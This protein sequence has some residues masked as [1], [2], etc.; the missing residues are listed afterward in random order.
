MRAGGTLKLFV[1]ACLLGV[2]VWLVETRVDDQERARLGKD[3]VFDVNSEDVTHFSISR[4]DFR[5]GFARKDGAW[6]LDWPVR[7]RADAGNVERVLSALE[8]LPSS[9]IITASERRKRGL[10]LDDYGLVE[11]RAKFVVTSRLREREVLVG[12]EAPL[13]NLVYVRHRAGDD[14]IAVPSELL[15]IAPEDVASMRDR[16]IMRGEVAAVSA[17]EI[18]TPA[19]GFLRLVR[20]DGVWFIKQPVATR[21]DTAE[22][23]AVLDALFGLT[24]DRFV[25]DPVLQ[26]KDGQGGSYN[27][28]SAP[29][30]TLDAY[31]LSQDEATLKARV[32]INGHGVGE[33]LILGKQTPEDENY[34]YAKLRDNDS[35]FTVKKNAIQSL[36]VS[37]A[38]LRS[39][40]LFAMK[41]SEVGRVALEE[42]GHRL[43]LER[44]GKTG[45]TITDPVNW[46]AETPKV[47]GYLN[48]LLSL[49]AVE[50]VSA[51]ASNRAL[52]GLDPPDYSV[53]LWREDR[54]EEL[55]GDETRGGQGGGG[56][57]PAISMDVG[58]SQSNVFVHV[59]GDTAICR[60]APGSLTGAGADPADPLIY[61]SR[62]ILA[63]T[64]A[65]VRRINLEKGAEAQTVVRNED[66]EW[67]PDPMVHQAGCAALK[68][69]VAG[70]LNVA[71]NMVVE[72]FLIAA[73]DQPGKYGL[74][75]PAA[76]LT[77]GLSGEEG[78]QKSLVIGGDAGETGSY[79]AIRGED[80][81]FVLSKETLGA[82]T[83][84][85]TKHMV[86][87]TETDEIVK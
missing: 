82:V 46:P 44:D 6:F 52:S 53:R 17:L 51:T 72:Q 7:A 59:R 25:W 67:M 23:V 78:I 86:R 83:N 74:D 32:W 13:G 69:A 75:K 71:S 37:V 12:D 31:R 20:E 27:I 22:V 76:V 84:S 50:F 45:W 15:D 43:V 48:E 87:S 64:P 19:S 39:P 65:S 35:I 5:I 40:R 63:V 24:I 4:N 42:G 85:I 47:S 8:T 11:P 80:V 16:N 26:S 36:R 38:D 28:G 77:L 57:D 60:L 49:E 3:R 34:V 1:A 58:F 55:A 18:E 30:A 10:D 2:F 14:V 66:G 79:A 73:E 70:I 21:A 41:A 62:V 61:R 9:E 29:K 81:V 33:E 54:A 56:D 68:T